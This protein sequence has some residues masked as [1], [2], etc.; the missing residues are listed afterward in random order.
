MTSAFTSME[1]VA[2]FD[3]FTSTEEQQLNGLREDLGLAAGENF[4][5]EDMF[6]EEELEVLNA[7]IDEDSEEGR[8]V[9]DLF[10]KRLMA[11]ALVEVTTWEKNRAEERNA[12]D[13]EKILNTVVEIQE[14]MAVLT[15]K[16]NAVQAKKTN[17]HKELGSWLDR[18]NTWKNSPA[19]VQYPQ[20]DKAHKAFYAGL[21]DRKEAYAKVNDETKPVIA[22]LWAKWNQ[23]K[24]Q[25]T[26]IGNS[27][28]FVWT[29]FFNL[30]E[31]DINPYFTNGDTEDVDDFSLLANDQEAVIDM[32]AHSHLHEMSLYNMPE[33]KGNGFWNLSG[34]IQAQKEKFQ[35]EREDYLN[36]LMN[37][38]A[39]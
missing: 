17:A 15:K 3:S 14:E 8:K 1:V 2:E 10:R 22:D 5:L 37:S 38:V 20:K 23:L 19:Y 36:A 11:S 12:T 29:L 16:I 24:A 28:P 13:H 27:N 35:A 39:A 33:S 7:E 18:F 21:K 9:L 31:E 32:L 25:S 34:H 6:S 4:I 30:V 26:A